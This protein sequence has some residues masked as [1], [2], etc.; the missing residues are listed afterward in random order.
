MAEEVTAAEGLPVSADAQQ[1]QTDANEHGRSEFSE[2]PQLQQTWLTLAVI[3]CRRTQERPRECPG[4]Y[5]AYSALS[6]LL[7]I[8]LQEV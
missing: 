7:S 3:V 2:K 5:N 6:I 1:K 4:S 8:S